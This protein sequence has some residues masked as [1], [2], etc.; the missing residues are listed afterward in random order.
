[1]QL[2]AKD[3]QI[4]RRTVTQ[5]VRVIL[6]SCTDSVVKERKVQVL[7]PDSP[8]VFMDLDVSPEDVGPNRTY[9][10][11]VI[12]PGVTITFHIKPGQ[13]L[14]AATDKTTAEVSLIVESLG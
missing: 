9:K 10:L 6:P 14:V 3:T 7:I 13:Y 12:P 4:L 1:M 8:K 2:L 11:P 5:E